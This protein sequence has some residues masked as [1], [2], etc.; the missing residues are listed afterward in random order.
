MQSLDVV[1][2]SLAHIRRLDGLPQSTLWN[3]LCST[4]KS[5]ASRLGK[6]TL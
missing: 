6:S 5:V 2:E 3:T 1:I 4:G